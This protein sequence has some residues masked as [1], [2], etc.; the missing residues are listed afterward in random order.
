MKNSAM[1]FIR[2]V[3]FCLLCAIALAAF[4]PVTK[5]FS[6]DWKEH[7]LLILAIIVTYGLVIL[8]T[9]WEKLPL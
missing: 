5:T 9:K 4:S 7:I 2:A 8:F 1:T 6:T 3:L